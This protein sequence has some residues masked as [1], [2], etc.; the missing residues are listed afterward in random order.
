MPRLDTPDKNPCSLTL[1]VERL[2]FLGKHSTRRVKLR[3]PH[4]SNWADLAILICDRPEVRPHVLNAAQHASLRPPPLPKRKKPKVDLT[5]APSAIQIYRAIVP[6]EGLS[7]E[8]N[9]MQRHATQRKGV[10]LE[11]LEKGRGR[12]GSCQKQVKFVLRVVQ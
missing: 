3:P 8:C 4:T 1:R 11:T 7:C 10:C 5:F 12:S 6:A 9:R 2:S